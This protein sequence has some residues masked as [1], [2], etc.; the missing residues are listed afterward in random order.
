MPWSGPQATQQSIYDRPSVPE[1]GLDPLST[2]IPTTELPPI[3]G[4]DRRSIARR[5]DRR[6]VIWRKPSA[7]RSELGSAVHAF[8]SSNHRTRRSLL[9]KA[10]ECESD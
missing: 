7:N 3:R 1:G 5:P 4:G 2:V 9:V 10:R 6:L 8:R